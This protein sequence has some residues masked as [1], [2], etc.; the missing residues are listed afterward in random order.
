MQLS[1]GPFL[2]ICMLLLA[3]SIMTEAVQRGDIEEYVRQF[4]DQ[5]LLYDGTTPG[6]QNVTAAFLPAVPAANQDISRA[7]AFARR[8]DLDSARAIAAL[9]AYA[10]I[11]YQ[12]IGQG[13]NRD[14]LILREELDSNGLGRRNWGMYIFAKTGPRGASYGTPISIQVPHPVFDRNTPELG[15]RTF[16]ETNADSFFIAGIYRYSTEAS[17]EPSTWSNASSS[18]MAHNEH[19]LFLQLAEDFTRPAA[20]NYSRGQRA[21]TVIQIH[22]FGNSD[23]E[24]G[25]WTYNPKSSYPQIV[26]SNGDKSLR[27][28]RVAI[29]DRLS[30]EFWKRAPKSNQRMTTGVYNGWEY[31]D[32]GATGNVVGRRIRARGDGS[33]FIHIEADPSIRVTDAWAQA[34][35]IDA[36]ADRAEKYGRFGRTLRLVLTAEDGPAQLIAQKL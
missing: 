6:H 17:K 19:S 7:V 12:D 30:Q 15:I 11:E 23:M 9:Y 21:T 20:F 13:R 3:F 33:T 10:V 31:S 2:C 32:L 22:G 18:D 26:L 24:D 36:H 25:K 14:Y 5:I 4:R 27:G 16:V 34:R 29:L 1:V 8:G 28:K 35:N